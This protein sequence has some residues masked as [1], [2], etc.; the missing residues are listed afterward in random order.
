M[1]CDIHAFIEY[2]DSGVK[3]PFSRAHYYTQ[4]QFGRC[5][6]LFNLMAGV[7]GFG[8]PVVAQK[9]MP[10][11][12]EIS[13]EVFEMSTLAITD[14]MPSVWNAHCIHREEADRLVL[15]GKADY[16]T[17]DKS[18]ITHPH[19]HSH[20]W[21]TIDELI[22]VRRKFLLENIHYDNSTYKGKKLKD[23]E[24]KILTSD[25][26]ELMRSVFPSIEYPALNA[27]IAA[28]IAL[29]KSE[30]YKTRLVFWFDS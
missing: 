9:G 27:T 1:G 12:P 30:D 11:S 28:M 21:L 29:E 5:Y 15:D 25:P 3:V 22:E 2:Y 6:T 16:V 17:V 24:D 10:K 7:R 23:A 26:V 20:T 13:L 8:P 4:P 18:R 19:I 14:N